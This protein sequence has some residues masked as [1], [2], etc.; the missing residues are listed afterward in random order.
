MVDR[1]VTKYVA[2]RYVRLFGGRI[3]KVIA[4]NTRRERLYLRNENDFIIAG[5][6]S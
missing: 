6:E 1:W 4:I 5:I 3:S 2:V